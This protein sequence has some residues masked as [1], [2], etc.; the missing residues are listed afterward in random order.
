MPPHLA[1]RAAPSFAGA[2]LCFAGLG[3][4]TVKFLKYR[5]FKNIRTKKLANYDLLLFSYTREQIPLLSQVP[6]A[7]D[8]FEVLGPPLEVHT[9]R[10]L[11]GLRSL[12][13]REAVLAALQRK[14]VAFG[15]QSKARMTTFACFVKQDRDRRVRRKQIAAAV[16]GQIAG[17]FGRWK[18]ADP[19]AVE[20]WGF[21]LDSRLHLGLRLSDHRLR[22]RGRA[23]QE[24]PGALRPT[25][26]AAMV[27][28]AALQADE[29]CVDPMC[30]T[31][32]LLREG[33]AQCDAARFGGGDIDAEAVDMARAGL[34]GVAL[35]AWDARRLPLERH[36]VDCV[37]TNLPFGRQYG[38]TEDNRRLYG[39]LLQHWSQKLRPGGRMVLLT[40]DAAALEYHLGTLGFRW[41]IAARVKVLGVWARIYHVRH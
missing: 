36:S 22:Y 7:E 4:L 15:R 2:L 10:D 34:G 24:R 40:A 5:N 31:G 25:I 8:V 18:A 32:T 33:R 30:G 9:G 13:S 21:Y 14:N 1:K 37:L 19:A 28:V 20:F 35:E 6:T 39:E 3:E 17:L 26:A 23:P 12:L 38:S 41:Y 11:Q 16:S 27:Q 29:V